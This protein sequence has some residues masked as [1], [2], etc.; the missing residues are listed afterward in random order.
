M[1]TARLTLGLTPGPR[2]FKRK[3]REMWLALLIERHRSKDEILAAYLNS[4][5]AGELNVGFEAAAKSYLGKSSLRLSPAE[6][7]LLAGLPAAPS[8]YNPHRRPEQAKR[9]RQIIIGRMLDQG[10]ISADA[11]RRALSEPLSLQP[12]RRVWR[13]PHFVGQI[14]Q[15]LGAFP[16]KTVIASLDLDLQREVESL[17]AATV[18]R[19]SGYGLQQAAVVVLS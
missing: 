6:A 11:A 4:A 16:P 7:A 12:P 5:P 3:L 9:R 10:R 15:R 17:A 8:R 14:V 1:Q 19:F 2:T 18:R 13:A